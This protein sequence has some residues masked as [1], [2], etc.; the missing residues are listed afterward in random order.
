MNL[1]AE[2]S[3][4]QTSMCTCTHTPYTCI[5][6]V[7]LLRGWKY[8]TRM[9]TG[10]GWEGGLTSLPNAIH[11]NLTVGSLYKLVVLPL[12]Y[13]G[14]LR[15]CYKYTSL[16]YH[17]LKHEGCICINT[18]QFQYITK[19]SFYTDLILSTRRVYFTHQTETEKIKSAAMWICLPILMM[20]VQNL[21]PMH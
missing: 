14:S 19:K 12:A 11:C 16:V 18:V 6:A 2:P 21:E 1:R 7:R 9:A 3:T 20:C 15:K 4:T 10:M 17:L 5:D 8:I 13:R